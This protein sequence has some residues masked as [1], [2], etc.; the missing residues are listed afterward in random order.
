MSEG[1]FSQFGS[2][3]DII[4]LRVGVGLGLLVITPLVAYIRKQG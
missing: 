3:L 4:I 2:L 1:I